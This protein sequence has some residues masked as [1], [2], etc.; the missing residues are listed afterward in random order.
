M[1][2]INFLLM[3]IL[4]FFLVLFSLENA[5]SVA[6]NVFPN[7]K[8]QL[9]L[10]ILLL[11]AVSFGA[12]FAW[13]FS[14]WSRMAL[15]VQTRVDYHQEKKDENILPSSKEQEGEEDGR[16]SKAIVVEATVP[17]TTGQD[18]EQNQDREESM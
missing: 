12:T 17:I 14:L 8:I 2:Q 18:Q 10:I 3:T 1:K 15:W 16:T 4:A 7:T 13:L 6:I 5:D 11:I 9:P